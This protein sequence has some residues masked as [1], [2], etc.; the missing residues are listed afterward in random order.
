M[1]KVFLAR[2]RVNDALA[3]CGAQE[4]LSRFKKD[5][6]GVLEELTKF[7][8]KPQAVTHIE[9]HGEAI[10]N[11]LDLAHDDVPPEVIEVVSHVA[12]L[13]QGINR[14]FSDSLRAKVL[15]KAS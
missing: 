8:A 3:L 12:E 14:N 9:R 7:W 15:A 10:L 1:K 5:P 6:A 2:A 4:A 13:T 11:H